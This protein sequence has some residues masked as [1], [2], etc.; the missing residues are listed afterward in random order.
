MITTKDERGVYNN[1]AKDPIAS[2]TEYPS[3]AKQRQYW[4]LGAITTVAMMGV[5]ALAVAVS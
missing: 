1:F 5:V 2:P 3:P 4:I